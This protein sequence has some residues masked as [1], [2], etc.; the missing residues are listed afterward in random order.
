MIRT[1]FAFAIA[2]LV[3]AA[4]VPA[5][6]AA[7]APAVATDPIQ[8]VT[9]GKLTFN[10]RPRF[11]YVDQDGKTDHAEA[12]TM[13]TLLGWRTLPFHGV[14]VYAEAIDVTR[15]GP[16]HFNDSSTASARYPT[17]ADPGD[18][19]INQLYVDYAGLPDTKVRF[20]RQSLKLDNVRYIGNVEFRQVMQVLTGLWVENKSLPG[21]ELDY[22][23]FV[24]VKSIFD[25]QRQTRLDLFRAA[26]IFR[27]DNT[28]VGY[29]YFQDQPATGQSTGFSDNSNRILGVRANGAVPLD[30]H[31]KLPYT[32]EYAKQDAYA[33]GNAAI[34]AHYWRAG[35]GVQYDK[36][37]VRVDREVLGSNGGRY[38]FQTPLG[39]NHLFQGWADLFLTTPAQGIR[40]TYV[41]A[42]T[43]AG[44]VLVSTEY[45]D[46]R[47]DFGS[48]KL[49]T[50]WDV[51]AAYGFTKRLTGKLELARFREG[52][53]LPTRFRD[54]TKV[55]VTA[56]YNY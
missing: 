51:G 28:L 16:Q 4:A 10:L 3:G 14:S 36:N 26:W 15:I 39:T 54:T 37:Y 30:T 31:W 48:Q 19:D 35:L 49:G 23:H 18:T 44:D 52:D 42:G 45:H 50:E 38:A 34:D 27:P 5:S 22:G 40:D 43:T 21:V 25:V 13:R 53:V 32:A 56:V 2:L 24:R 55:W 12:L 9:D 17:V 1:P 46:F 8:S 6:H 33:D 29:G 20:G 41:S 47:S 7:D 11:E